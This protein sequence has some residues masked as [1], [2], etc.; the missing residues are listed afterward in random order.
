[1]DHEKV[2]HS[3]WEPKE[4]KELFLKKK[5]IPSYSIGWKF[6]R[7]ENFFINVSCEYIWKTEITIYPSK[8]LG[9]L[10]AW[11]VMFSAEQVASKAYKI[12]VLSDKENRICIVANLKKKEIRN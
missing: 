3:R 6:L 10:E 7:G 12:S 8:E 5:E 4:L 9:V 1:V 11:S 2:L